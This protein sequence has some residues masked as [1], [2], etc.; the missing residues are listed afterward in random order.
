ML[1]QE[2]VNLAI[3]FFFAVIGGIIANR[4]KQPAV[5]GLLIVGALIGPHAFNLVKDTEMMG[6]IVEFG[7]ILLLFVI[8]LEFS[9][10]KFVK[11]GFKAMMIGVF[12]I[13]IIYFFTYELSLIIGLS[14]QAATVF[15]VILSLSS[16]VAIVR[17]LQSKGLYRERS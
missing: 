11:V 9:L 17:I 15:A 5:I 2:L 6:S 7:A 3:L 12:K 1:G 10:P 16:T 4:F 14:Q 8:G 13:G